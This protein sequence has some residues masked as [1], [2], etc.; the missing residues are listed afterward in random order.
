METKSSNL[1]H[2][3]QVHTSSRKYILCNDIF[4]IPSPTTLSQNLLVTLAHTLMIPS[5]GIFFNHSL[6][7]PAHDT[8]RITEKQY[9]NMLIIQRVWNNLFMPGE[10]GY[11]SLMTLSQWTPGESLHHRCR[12]ILTSVCPIPTFVSISPP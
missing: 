7:T 11:D 9:S 3:S 6:I 2:L 5:R 12:P 4:M 8:L 10:P 1:H